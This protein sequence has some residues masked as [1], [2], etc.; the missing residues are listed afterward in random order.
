MQIYPPAKYFGG[1]FYMV[2]KIIPLIRPSEVYIEGYLGM[3]NILLNKP[4]CKY[5]FGIDIDPNVIFMWKC[6]KDKSIAIHM[7][8]MM[9]N[10]T[11][12]EK[13][14]DVAKQ[15]IE[16]HDVHE[17]IDCNDDHT[18]AFWAS[19]YIVRSR[20][21]R[22]GLGKDFGTSTRL[23]GGINEYKNSW[24]NFVNNRFYPIYER[25]KDVNFFCGDFEKEVRRLNLYHF[26]D[27]CDVVM[28]LDPPYEI[29]SRS[30]KKVY[31]YEM[32][33]DDH[34]KMLEFIKSW[35]TKTYLS[36]YRNKIYD[37]ALG[38]PQH[39]FAVANNSAQTKTK[40]RRVECVWEIN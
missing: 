22:L 14:F 38:N 21:S 36:G 5:E 8:Y 3:G 23:R 11:Y 28:Y 35:N 16:D 39:E 13:N 25:V 24:K 26:F 4:K 34:K 40:S 30:T 6:V 7:Q 12:D 18:K 32:T 17:F 19:M 1:K 2:R 10:T 9:R 27:D 15:Y 29:S 33:A 37:D 31:K 20:F